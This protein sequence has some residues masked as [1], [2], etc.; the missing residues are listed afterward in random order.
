ML[1][2]YHLI[3]GEKLPSAGRGGFGFITILHDPNSADA[4]MTQEFH[5]FATGGACAGGLYRRGR[6]G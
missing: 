2:N 5:D 1:R 3:L 6:R 4:E